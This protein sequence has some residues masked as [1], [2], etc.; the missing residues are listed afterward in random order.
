MEAKDISNNAKINIVRWWYYSYDMKLSNNIHSYARDYMNNKTRKANWVKAEYGSNNL[1]MSNENGT[2]YIYGF[3][4]ANQWY[5]P[6]R[7][8]I[9][10]NSRKSSQY[11]PYYLWRYIKSSHSSGRHFTDV[12]LI[13]DSNLPSTW[14]YIVNKQGN[15]SGMSSIKNVNGAFW[16]FDQDNKQDIKWWPLDSGRWP[17]Y[18]DDL[19]FRWVLY[20]HG[21]HVYLKSGTGRY[22]YYSSSN[23]SLMMGSLNDYNKQKVGTIGDF[24]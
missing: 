1:V 5:N 4:N 20:E 15:S 13:K 11:S 6:Y 12:Y 17:I 8:N 19:R 7:Y 14:F 22:M 2:N 23:G 21:N 16:A 3:D 9:N 18:K 10:M 24:N